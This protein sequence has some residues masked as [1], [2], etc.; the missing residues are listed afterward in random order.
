[1]GKFF[2]LPLGQRFLF[3]AIADILWA[4]ARKRGFVE[5]ALCV[6]TSID[7]LMYW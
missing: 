2:A 4:N 1:M 7:V 6:N 3:S 5:M